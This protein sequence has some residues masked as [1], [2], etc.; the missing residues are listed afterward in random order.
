[1]S[2]HPPNGPSAAHGPSG[3]PAVPTGF[4]GAMSGSPAWPSPPR[5]PSRW[6]T[7][8]AL[9]L[10]L[11]ASGF[12]IAGWFRPSPAAPPKPSTGPA[13]TEQQ[14]SDAKQR[15][16]AAFEV[17]QK[18]TTL[19]TNPSPTDDAAMSNAQAAHAQL[20]LVAGGWYLR[21]HLEPATPSQ[22]ADELHNLANTML[23]IGINA[24]AG[25]K[26]ADPSQSTLIKDGNDAV[27]RTVEL[28]K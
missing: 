8:L 26:N 18:G 23:D 9:A 17:V 5:G 22:L 27:D 25:A 4:P 16:C 15:A 14:V 28:C 12:A 7:F 2:E 13:Y 21:D 19:Q 20:S 24:L 1:M 6:P 11:V 3:Y 10:A